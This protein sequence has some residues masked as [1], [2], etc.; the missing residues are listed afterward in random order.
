M[1]EKTILITGAN[2][3]IGKNLL[4][5]LIESQFEVIG[6]DRKNGD[7]TDRNTFNHLKDKKIDHVVHLAARTYVPESWVKPDLFYITNVI[8][9]LNVLEFCKNKKVDLTYVSAYLYGVP[10]KLPVS[11]NDILKPNNPYAHSKFLA[12]KL[13]EFYSKEFEIKVTIL[14]PFNVYG[15]GQ[16]SRFLIPKIIHQALNKDT[17]KVET[18]SPKRDFIYVK[19]LLNAIFKT[20]TISKNFSIYNV[21]SGYSI[22]VRDVIDTIQ[23]V[24]NSNKEII[25]TNKIRK[26]EIDNAFFDI[27][28][29][30][31]ELGWYPE[32][33]F[34][35]GIRDI[36]GRN[37]HFLVP[38]RK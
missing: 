24:C 15:P 1:K 21:G 9:T 38:N 32:Y 8:G 17:I 2:G 27:S 11:E 12:E 33:V 3:F 5:F 23:K 6:L 22:S 31:T 29:I 7:V 20:F 14:R 13:C 10:D 19:D 28:K 16:D 18:L 35:D 26:N 30:S 34:E 36:I 4:S 37:T 25:V